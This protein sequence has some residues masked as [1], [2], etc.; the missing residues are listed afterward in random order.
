MKTS[1]M[2]VL[3]TEKPTVTVDIGGTVRTIQ[4]VNVTI[5]CQVAGEKSVL[6]FLC[7][8]TD[9]ALAGGWGTNVN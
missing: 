6:V 4:R 1:R 9:G 8:N 7:S 2:T 5:N 3:N